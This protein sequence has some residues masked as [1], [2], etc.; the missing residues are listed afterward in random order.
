MNE[1]ITTLTER[2]QTSIP[3]RIRRDMH[4][5]PGTKLRWLEVSKNECHIIIEEPESGPGA[6]AMLGY[7][8]EFRKRKTTKEWMKEL[9]DGEELS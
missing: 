7:A 8:D 1:Q 9:R 5:H 3:S 2:G 6:K 4:M